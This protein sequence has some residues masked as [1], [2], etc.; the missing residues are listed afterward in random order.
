MASPRA[1]QDG[2]VATAWKGMQGR[3]GIVATEDR[4]FISRCAR[5]HE[6]THANGSRRAIQQP[7]VTR[8]SR[9]RRLNWT[10]WNYWTSWNNWTSWNHWTSWNLRA[11][12][13]PSGVE[14]EMTPLPCQTSFHFL[15]A[16]CDGLSPDARKYR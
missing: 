16:G 6:H 2:T 14:N 11:T 10:S 4:A 7:G 1:T 3:D 15:S 8:H 5:C 13:M 12:A 9:L